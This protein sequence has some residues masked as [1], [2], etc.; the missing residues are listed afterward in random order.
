M[1][2]NGIKGFNKRAQY[3][4]FRHTE[5]QKFLFIFQISECKLG[6]QGRGACSQLHIQKQDKIVLY[7]T[8]CLQKIISASPRNYSQ[9]CQISLF[10]TANIEDL[11]NT[12]YILDIVHEI[13][14]KKKRDANTAFLAG[15]V[16][17]GVKT[18]KQ[19]NAIYYTK[20]DTKKQAQIARGR[21]KFSWGCN[22]QQNDWCRVTIQKL[23]YR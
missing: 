6:W 11:M 1:N 19:I 13:V 7:I 18:W 14:K 3:R 21:E 5:L 10:I 8:Y 20:F 15:R 23:V 17:E 9:H 4:A 2:I 22:A 12:Y 16:Q